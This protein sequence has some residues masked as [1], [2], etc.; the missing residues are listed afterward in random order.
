MKYTWDKVIGS[1][2]FA[3]KD[4]TINKDN[5]LEAILLWWNEN[6]GTLS[7]GTYH[8]TRWNGNSGLVLLELEIQSK[9]V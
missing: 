1:H 6:H 9:P 7:K 4:K 5:N 3:T 2:T 8:L